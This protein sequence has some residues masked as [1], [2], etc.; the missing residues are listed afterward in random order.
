MS[1]LVQIL[2]HVLNKAGYLV[3]IIFLSLSQIW[4]FFTTYKNMN[5]LYEK[6]KG[7]PEWILA[8]KNQWCKNHRNLTAVNLPQNKKSGNKET[9]CSHTAWELK[10]NIPPHQI[11]INWYWNLLST[12]DRN[13]QKDGFCWDQRVMDH[14]ILSWDSGNITLGL[15]THYFN[16]CHCDQIVTYYSV[17]LS[18]WHI[19]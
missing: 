19:G 8:K 5:R 2:Y 6:R 3:E 11:Y 10:T 14:R 1:D 16:S 4:Q 17:F 13:A 18:L 9:L 12:C 7:L 15:C